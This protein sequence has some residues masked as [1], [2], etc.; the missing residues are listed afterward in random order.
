MKKEHNEFIRFVLV[1]G[2]NTV[3]Y[4]L[5]YLVSFHFLS[6]S[7]MISHWAAFLISMVISFYL[8]VYFTYRVKPTLNKFLQFPLTQ[9]VNFSASSILMY[10]LVQWFGVSQYIA[11]IISVFFTVPITFLLTSKIL[12][13][14]K[15]VS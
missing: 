5:I 7:Y 9:I 6:I 14:E 11:P 3:N 2:I 8:N 10:V 12:K 1:G 4:Y 15:V 13:R